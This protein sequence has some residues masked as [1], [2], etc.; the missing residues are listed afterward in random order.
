M[1]NSSGITSSLPGNR[2]LRAKN[3]TQR[4]CLH[5]E[6]RNVKRSILVTKS[7]FLNYSQ[8]LGHTGGGGLF[9]TVYDRKERFIPTVE[10]RV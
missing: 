1:R 7:V 10:R 4:V 3:P 2:H 9:I 6:L 8:P 5:K